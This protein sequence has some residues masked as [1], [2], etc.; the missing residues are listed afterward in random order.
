MVP[1]ESLRTHMSFDGLCDVF[2][3]LGF[4]LITREVEGRQ[5]PII[6][7]I[8]ADNERAFNT[9]T[10]AADIQLG[11]GFVAERN[12][13]ENL[14]RRLSFDDGNDLVHVFD[15]DLVVADVQARHRPNGETYISKGGTGDILG[16]LALTCTR[17]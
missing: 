2:G 14:H 4:E 7:E 6:L 9:E 10:L 13:T 15:G 12:G 11:D 17:E 1:N 5:R 16:V 8:T 3:T